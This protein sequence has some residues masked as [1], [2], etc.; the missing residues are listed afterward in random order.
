[1]F[2]RLLIYSLYDKDGIVDKY[3]EYILNKIEPYVNEIAVIVNGKLS[4]DGRHKLDNIKKIKKI[5]VRENEGF[6]IW[7]YK[8]GMESYGWEKLSDFDEII[9]M[10]DTIYGPVDSFDE[11][12]STMDKK[13]VDFW[14]ITLRNNKENKMTEDGYIQSYFTAIRKHMIQSYDFQKYWDDLPELNIDNDVVLKHE[15]LFTKK[16][17]DYGFSWEV[18][19]DSEELRKHS[20]DPLFYDPVKLLKEY[21]C[22]VFLRMNFNTEYETYLRYTNGEV[23]DELLE[24]LRNN[25]SY[26]T[27]MIYRNIARI[28]NQQDMKNC[29]HNNFIISSKET[30][31]SYSNDKNRPKV[32]LMLHLYYE[33]LFKETLEYAKNMPKEADIYISTQTEEKKKIIEELVKDF[34]NKVTV[35]V[36]ENRGRDVSALLIGFKDYVFNYDIICTAHDKK[37]S[38][39]SDAVKGK[40]F[41]YI[42]FENT[43]STPEYVEN[44]IQQFINDKNIG[45]LVPPPPQFAEYYPVINGPYSGWGSNYDLCV[46]FI[47][48]YKINVDI[49]KSKGPVAPYGTMFWFRV[50][51]LKPLYDLNLQYKD[52]PAEPASIDGTISHAIERLYPCFAQTAGYYSACVMSDKFARIQLTNL[53]YILSEL[54]YRIFSIISMD[55]LENELKGIEKLGKIQEEYDAIINS[56]SWKITRPLRW[57]MRKLK[58]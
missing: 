19:V 23:V 44:I 13:N 2:E 20:P 52:F 31:Y 6:D 38:Q 25:A 58:K 10:N 41:A 51:A 28:S 21:K 35:I 32:A 55:Y 15:C 17:Q 26:N 45:L 37:V 18:Y 5:I 39:L 14:G 48:K 54:N 16:F 56:K 30:K 36:I 3:V 12:F 27:D 24:Y 29:M 9:L 8:T 40:S 50:D 46:N 4:V 11:M 43:L 33:D 53:Q 1:M 22:P 7:G 34:P 49:I 42:C 57:I 47:E